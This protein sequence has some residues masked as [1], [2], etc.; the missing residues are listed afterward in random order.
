[1][2]S[3]FRL[4]LIALIAFTANSGGTST[5]RAADSHE[6][7]VADLQC[8]LTSAAARAEPVAE[9]LF[10]NV[11]K[12][13]AERS[14][15]TTPSGPALFGAA[16]PSSVRARG[17]APTDQRRVIRL[18]CRGASDSSDEPPEPPRLST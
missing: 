14:K 1:M 8:A 9:S 6:Q 15:A 18:T 2:C 16:I 12:F 10:F 7:S 17:R 3:A 4:M 13:R 11:E 5:R